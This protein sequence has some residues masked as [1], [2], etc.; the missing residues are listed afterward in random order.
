MVKGIEIR[1]ETLAD[2]EDFVG[3]LEKA[4]EMKPQLLR[5]MRFRIMLADMRRR[6]KDM[7]NREA[8]K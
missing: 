6:L 2:F 4:V 7:R 8:K 1:L 5:D 3:K